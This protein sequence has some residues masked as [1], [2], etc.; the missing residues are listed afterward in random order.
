MRSNLIKSVLTF[1]VFCLCSNLSWAQVVTV[2][3]LA[4]STMGFADGQGSAAKFSN[5]VGLAVDGAGNIYVGDLGNNRI[6]KITPDGNVT[7]LAGS[8]QGYADGQV[9]VAKFSGPNGV[10]V[11]GAGTIYVVDQSNHKIRKI[12]PG[13]NVTTLAGS[14]SGLA[15]G[16]GTAAKFLYPAGVAVDGAGNSYIA[17]TSNHV[18]RKI[19]PTGNVTTLAGSTQ[20]YADGQGSAA[21]FNSPA[22]VAADAAG[23]IYVADQTNNKIRK[24]TPNGSVTT[25]AGSTFG[26]ADG[27]GSAAKFSY[28]NTLAVDGAGNIYVA[29]YG[30]HLIRKITP[31]GNVT[32]LAGSTPGFADGQGSAAKFSSPAGVALDGAGNI[33]VTDF[34]N[35]RIRKISLFVLP[36]PSSLMATAGNNKVNLSWTANA[37]TDNVTGYKVYRGTS[38]TTVS[39]LL[40]SAAITETTYT[41]N[42]AIG[43]TTYYYAVTA[44]AAGGESVNSEVASATPVTLPTAPVFTSIPVTELNENESYSYTITAK[45]VNGDAVNFSATQLPAWLTLT[46]KPKSTSVRSS[47]INEA[48]ILASDADNNIYATAF[49]DDNIYKI[50]PDGT[51]TTLCSRSSSSSVQGM[52]VYNNIL[53]VSNLNPAKILKIDLAHPESGL[54]DFFSFT[55]GDQPTHLTVNGGVLYVASPWK[56]VYKIDIN[57]KLQTGTIPFPSAIADQYYLNDIGFNPAGKLCFLYRDINAG[58]SKISA[59]TISTGIY[60]NVVSGLPT[61]AQGM[62]FD[63]NGKLYLALGAGGAVKYAPDFTSYETIIP[64]NFD[65]QNVNTMKVHVTDDNAAVISDYSND[66][67]YVATEA[68][69]ILTGI[70]TYA[71]VGTHDV[72]LLA[73]DGT[74]SSNQ[75][76][77]ITVKDVTAPLVSAFNPVANAANVALNANLTLTFNENIKKGTGDIIIKRSA[78]N[79]VVETIDVAGSQVTITD[80][81]LTINPANSFTGLTELYVILDATA[82]A[83]MSGNA[84]AGIAD[85]S[86][87]KFKTTD[88]PKA[89][90]FTSTPVT[91]VNE[92]SSYSYTLKATDENGDVLTYSAEQIPSWLR[93]TIK[94]TTEFSSTIKY[95][96]AVAVDR[97][98]NVYAA[99]YSGDD[100]KIFKIT[101]DGTTTEWATREKGIM[102]SMLILDDYLYLG[103][104][105]KAKITKIKLSN[106]AAGETLVV[107]DVYSLHSMDVKDGML[108]AALFQQGKV[109]KVNPATGASQDYLTVLK[110]TGLKFDSNG[111]LYLAT[112]ET[113]ETGKILKYAQGITAPA[114]E[115]LSSLNYPKAFGFDKAGKLY[116]ATNAGIITYADGV[117]N[118]YSTDFANAIESLP[119]GA[120]VASLIFE[121]KVVKLEP[122]AL[123]AGTPSSSNVGVHPVKLKVSDGTLSSNQEFNITVKDITAPKASRFTPVNN[124]IAFAVAGNISVLFNENVKKGTGYIVVKKLTDDSVIEKID[125]NSGLVSIAGNLLTINPAADL[126]GLTNVYV[127]V[128]ATAV[129]DT[130]G[131]AFAGIINNSTWRFKTADNIKPAISITSAAS[132]TTDAPFTATFTFNEKV[133]GFDQSDITVS[134]AT[135]SEFTEVRAGELYS[136]LISPLADGEVTLSIAASVVRDEALNGNTTSNVFSIFYTAP[137]APVNTAPTLDAV[138]NSTICY[139]NGQQTIA[140][141]GITAGAETDQTTTLSV[142]SDNNALFEKLEVTPSGTLNYQLKSDASGSATITVTVKDNGGTENG[143]VDTYSASF[144][145]TVNPLP[146]VAISSDLGTS[147]SKGLTATLTATG[148]SSY[149][150]DNGATTAAI[151]VRPDKTTTYHVTVTNNSGCSLVQTITIDVLSDYL[152]LKATNILT[153]NG[154]GV[155]DNFKIENLD[156]YPN[157]TLKVFDRAGRLIY[158]KKGYMNEWNGTLNGAPLAVGTYYYILDFGS[159]A[160]LLKGPI[161]IIRE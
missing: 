42:T 161:T 25:L 150:W 92:R 153:P 82:I 15:N 115:L 126:P 34:G 128:D 138:A 80:N 120:L 1:I 61:Y 75:N 23:N 10:A 77:T 154:D 104:Y 76:F 27:Q 81:V 16:Q 52:A 2:T 74:L 87:W 152:A 132:G 19:T 106:P 96:S 125:V 147:I 28:P 99:S 135:V 5:P 79:S 33:Y 47:G 94:A 86:T 83:D 151:P 156:L 54:T 85:N 149:T 72:K 6:R 66:K 155:N 113:D 37:S 56:L 88:L 130:T 64:T 102:R 71:A 124:E 73:S 63:K 118:V 84:F 49:Y 45:D 55:N 60:E 146:V 101:P 157:N 100:N 143:G 103:H 3:T 11:D 142:S 8:T 145:L 62:K 78:D 65:G 111:I 4:G 70:P 127:T 114:T 44:V 158:T 38:S 58:D 35:N 20:G 95:A 93:L 9:S 141:S 134:N 43:G 107:N 98:G 69:T 46:Q 29:D 117:K 26:F 7:T 50:S 18:I 148:G 17:E 159:G 39:D 109:I 32:T 119:S 89:P 51:T 30:N 123:L 90:V 131:N 133:T 108:Y 53:Y 22:G 112:T 129:T 13:G 57:T 97:D 160:S 40:T 14:T 91:E 105:E 68:A 36:A 67:I 24:I 121:N 137:E 110:P 48:R 144:S 140:L 122:Q 116:V 41:D 12:T 21:K 136:A 31:D 139:T 59:Y